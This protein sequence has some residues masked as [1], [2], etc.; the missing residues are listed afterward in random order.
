MWHSRALRAIRKLLLVSLPA[1]IIALLAL[2]IG[3]RLFVDVCDPAMVYFDTGTAILRFEPNQSGRHVKTGTYNAAYHINGAGWNSAN[4]YVAGPPTGRLRIAVIGDSYVEAVQVDYDKNLAAVLEDTLNATS[5]PPPVEVYSFGISGATLS[6][7][8]HMMRYVADTYR[9]DIYV[10]NIA[11]NDFQE[12]YRSVQAKPFLLQFELDDSGA[13]VEIPPSA[14]HPS[15][16]R[17]VIC[18]S[19]LVR[20]MAFN[21]NL[22]TEMKGKLQPDAASID[23]PDVAQD[24]PAAPLDVLVRYVFE[25]CAAVAEAHGGHLLFIID[26][27]R[28]HIYAGLPPEDQEQHAYNELVGQ[29]AQALA[30]PLLDLTDAFA[31]DYAA[32]QQRFDFLDDSHWNERGHTLVGTT[33]AATL[34]A[35][36]WV[37]PRP[38]AVTQIP[39]E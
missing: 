25:N 27:P 2:E 34:R 38:P 8:L 6:Q 3:L 36:D 12:S 22:L 33:L 31:T 19:A 10:I 20:F 7:Y 30:I 4:E 1:F 35:L 16:L 23:A 17:R 14:Y 18:K 37:K 32:H 13:I 28:A 29:T 15:R 5:D 39:A 9:P 24:E 11:Y 26:G 21:L